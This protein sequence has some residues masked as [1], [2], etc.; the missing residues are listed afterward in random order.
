[1]CRPRQ[2]RMLTSAQRMASTSTSSIVHASSAGMATVKRVG[3][4]PSSREMRYPV[5]AAVMQ[6]T[7][8]A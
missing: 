5:M 1:M 7:S 8:P 4:T 2:N 3:G 6:G